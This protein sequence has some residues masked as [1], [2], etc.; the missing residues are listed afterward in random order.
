MLDSV[1]VGVAI[2][3]GL[4]SGRTVGRTAVYFIRKLLRV[5]WRLRGSGKGWS[6][7]LRGEGQSL[8]A[9]LTRGGAKAGAFAYDCKIDKHTKLYGEVEIICETRYFV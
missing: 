4:C 1:D 8:E 2:N 9:S 7:R 3:L 5:G 6:L